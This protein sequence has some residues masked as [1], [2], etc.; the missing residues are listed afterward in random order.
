MGLERFIHSIAGEPEELISRGFFG[1][2]MS[3]GAG[4]AHGTLDT[5]IG[6]IDANPYNTTEPRVAGAVT[7][8]LSSA[9][10]FPA[11]KSFIFSGKDPE[12]DVV[13][14]TITTGAA[15]TVTFAANYCSYTAGYLMGR[16]GADYFLK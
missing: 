10:V 13:S 6:G 1:F 2:G 3:F 5:T 12:K 15:T 16:F 11:M 8:G 4:V 14:N 9:L 7:A